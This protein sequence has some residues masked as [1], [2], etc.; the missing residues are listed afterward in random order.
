MKIIIVIKQSIESLPPVI[1]L[2]DAFNSLEIESHLICTNISY[3]NFEKY[4]DRVFINKINFGKEKFRFLKLFSLFKFR[5]HFYKYIDS[6][7]NSNDTLIWIASAEASLVLGH[8]ISKYNFIFQCHELY[9]KVP[10]YRRIIGFY[11]KKSL[12]NVC[13]SEFR[14][15]IYR[16]WFSLNETPS[17]LLNKP[18]Y[19]PRKRCLDIDDIEAK[20]IIS[21]INDKKIILYQGLIST[22]RDISIIAEAT[23]QISNDWIFVIMGPTNSEKYLNQLLAKY[24]NIVYISNIQAPMHLQ[25]TSWARIGVLSYTFDSLNNTFCAPNKIWEYSGFGIPMIS[26]DVIGVKNI[27]EKHSSGICLNLDSSSLKDVIGAIEIIE[28]NY[29]KYDENAKEMY[30]STDYNQQLMNIV[31]Q[32]NKR[33]N[34]G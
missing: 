33:I 9:D 16:T 10:F 21:K 2:L 14:A 12:L 31:N 20:E 30:E 19:H 23:N 22:D 28:G 6:I 27:L 29:Q 3:D 8:K 13:P 5:K 18:F 25:I 15:A 26:S 17:L 32:S 1:N 24:D 11:F 4:K 7:Y 34:I